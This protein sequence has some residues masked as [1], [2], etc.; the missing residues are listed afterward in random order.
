MRA[1]LAG[2]VQMS[3]SIAL[4]SS[5][6]RLV[7]Q[8]EHTDV[9]TRAMSLLK[10]LYTIDAS[11][12]QRSQQL[13]RK[14][15]YLVEVSGRELVLRILEDLALRLH[16][17]IGVDAQQFEALVARDC[18]R[19]AFL[20]GAFLGSGS[21]SDP[22]K[23]YHTEFVV[24]MQEFALPLLNILNRYDL[25]G[26]LTVRKGSYIVYLKEIE[27]M[28]RLLTLTGAHSSVLELEN[29]RIL[30]EIRNNVNRQ[31]NC[32]NANIDRTINSAMDQVR[33][34]RKIADTVGLQTL[35][36][37]LRQTAELRL[38]NPEASLT[39]LAALSGGTTRSGINHRLRR[40]NQIAQTI[41]QVRE[42]E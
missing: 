24:S 31:L 3:A 12:A 19:A 8:T 4:G 29:I 30:K 25:N 14:S 20:R 15:T 1:E 39:E 2:M 16:A 35:P 27:N 36:T 41:T 23:I 13:K 40:I 5:G 33:C 6:L 42:D 9:V 10:R 32:D 21:I 18:C 28:I 26:K 37:G 38:A 11:L 22:N 17:G 34:I 7:L